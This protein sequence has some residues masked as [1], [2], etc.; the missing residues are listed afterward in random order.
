VSRLLRLYGLSVLAL[1]ALA[2]S[3]GAPAGAAL[4]CPAQTTTKPFVPWLDSG[5]YTQVQNGALE[6]TSGWTLTG[7]AKLVTG[8]EPWKVNAGTDS[9]SLLLP[10]GSSATSPGLCVTLLHPTLRF[11]ATNTGPATT[12]LKVEAVT[13]LLGVKTTTPV[14]LLVAGSWQPTLPLA[15]LDNLLSP[16][17]GTVQFRFTPVGSSSG[18]RVD[19]VYVDPYK[20][21]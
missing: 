5:N 2:A 3:T 8:N 14:G 13:T 7:G 11:F 16:V 19:D 15:F 6:S 9:R 10:S 21:R 4:T 20:Q 17:S 1:A 12:T 18:W